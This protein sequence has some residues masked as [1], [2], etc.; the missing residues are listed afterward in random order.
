MRAPRGKRLSRA[1]CPSQGTQYVVERTAEGLAL[2][3]VQQ[4][5]RENQL[6]MTHL[7]TNPP[8][9]GGGLLLLL[10]FHKHTSNSL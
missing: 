2:P 3:A 10:S 6:Q 4:H 8:A 9:C 7:I 5:E 1:V